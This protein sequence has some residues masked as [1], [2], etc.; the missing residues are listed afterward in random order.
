[1][2]TNLRLGNLL[3]VLFVGCGLV[4]CTTQAANPTGT[5][6]SGAGTGGNGAG[7]GGTTGSGGGTTGSGGTSGYATNTGIACPLPDPSGLISNFTYALV[8]GAAPDMTQVPFGTYGTTFSGGED[9]FGSL[10][11]NVTGSDWHIMGSIAD[12]SGW[13]LYFTSAAGD[14][15]AA[16]ACNKVN[17]SA[18]T[19]ISFTIWG[20][21]GGNMVTFGMGTLDDSVA[22]GWL[23]SKDGGSPSMPTPGTCTPTSGNGRYYHPGCA[24][25]TDVFAVTGT[26]AAPQ[27][28]SL[29]WNQF[30]GGMPTA[31]VTPSGIL[32]VYW[33]VPFTA[34]GTAYSVD[35]H[36]DNLAFTT[37]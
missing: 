8:D 18:F 34:G 20:T 28:V 12:Y 19:G 1:M 5:G 37:N 14:G 32:S 11:S 22:Y 33:S 9:A 3:G 15:A 35:L 7:T 24:D 29:K 16:N 2:S 31:G 13:N 21:A 6:G 36:I 23:D 26:Q 27:T 17:A 10:T 25:P 30:T 4:A